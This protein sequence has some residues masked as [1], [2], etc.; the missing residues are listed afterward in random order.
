MQTVVLFGGLEKLK[1]AWPLKVCG[2]T[3][4]AIKMAAHGAGNAVLVNLAYVDEEVTVICTTVIPLLKDFGG[5]WEVSSE[6][7]GAEETEACRIA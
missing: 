2:V 4:A 5:L 7:S 3:A 6:A 1:Y